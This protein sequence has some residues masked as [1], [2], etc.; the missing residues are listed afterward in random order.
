M[1]PKDKAEELINN[2]YEINCK[3]IKA[4]TYEERADRYKLLIP[5]CK[6]NAL[7][8]VDEII[9]YSKAHGFIELTKF[10]EEVKAEIENAHQH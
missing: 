3:F 10:Y 9:Q 7:Y 1:T 5:L 4:H 6:A 2:L 8:A